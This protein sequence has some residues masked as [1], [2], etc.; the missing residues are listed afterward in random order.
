MSAELEHKYG[1]YEGFLWYRTHKGTAY[2]KL[3]LECHNL[4]YPEVKRVRNGSSNPPPDYFDMYCPPH[5]CKRKAG[6]FPRMMGDF[7]LTMPPPERISGE[8]ANAMTAEWGSAHAEAQMARVEYP[9][10]DLFPERKKPHNWDEHIIYIEPHPANEVPDEMAPWRVNGPDWMQTVCDLCGRDVGEKKYIT[11]LRVLRRDGKA[12]PTGA[13]WPQKVD[14]RIC[15]T[16]AWAF[17]VHHKN[18]SGAGVYFPG[19]E[20]RV[21]EYG[22][23]LPTQLV[24]SSATSAPELPTP[25]LVPAPATEACTSSSSFSST[26]SSS[27]SSS[28]S[29]WD[30]SAILSSADED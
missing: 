20:M 17:H 23:A 10:R 3:C 4:C 1:E 6:V 26:S 21:C 24:A 5:R 27:S 9:M 11:T 30:S 25:E 19:V 2:W 18:N 29:W 13:A 7:Y 22:A 28:S 14:V 8:K 15:F 16:C 12:F